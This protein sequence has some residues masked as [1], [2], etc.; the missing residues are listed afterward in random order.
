MLK[1]V[2][3]LFLQRVDYV[4]NIQKSEDTYSEPNTEQSTH[5]CLSYK[6]TPQLLLQLF[7][8]KIEKKNATLKIIDVP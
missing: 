4:L 2:I 1:W 5:A 7:Y 6:T 3:Y 8:I